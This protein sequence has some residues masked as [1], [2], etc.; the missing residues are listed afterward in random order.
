MTASPV[1]DALAAFRA[2]GSPW[3]AL[4]FFADGKADAVAARVDARIAAGARVLP[5]PDRIFRALAET[6]LPA[7]RA[8]ILGQ[9]P[10]P[11]PGDANGLAF[12]YVGTGR[13][14]ASLKVI[15]AEAGSDRTAGGDLTPWA[16]QGVLLLNSALT[17]EAGKAGAHLRY[18][19]S[20]LTD[21]A[22]AAV[23]ARPEPAVFLLW[24]AQ[25]RA[26]A[27]LIDADRHGVFE[28]GH[29][30]PL[31]RARDYPGS[32]PFGRA[33]RWLAERGVRPIAWSL[34]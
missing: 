1:A 19:W 7:V 10:Y 29:P 20:A 28:S 33:N 9:D 32:D 17:V 13:L 6:P 23:S 24:G 8:V 15:L 2:S 14:P 30:S 27:A 3:L 12:S 22:V 34:G 21:D 11:T 4:P 5:A 25:A 18:G 26:R 16:R 31:N